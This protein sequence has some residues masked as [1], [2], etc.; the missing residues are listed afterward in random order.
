MIKVSSN[1]I[2]SHIMVADDC[3]NNCPFCMNKQFYGMNEPTYIQQYNLA[4]QCQKLAETPLR[5]F[6][7][8]GGEPAYDIEQLL[9][10]CDL[11]KDKNVCISTTLPYVTCDGFIE[12]VNTVDCIKYVNISRH[13]GKE[14]KEMLYDVASDDMIDEIIKPVYINVVPY[15]D[16]NLDEIMERWHNHNVYISVNQNIRLVDKKD[17]GVGKT[18]PKGFEKLEIMDAFLTN[19]SEH[20]YF[21]NKYNKQVMFNRRLQHTSEKV[22]GDIIVND[23]I[24]FPNGMF[25]YDFD[26][27]CIIND[28]DKFLE[29]VEENES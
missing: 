4:Y 12:L 19:Y 3:E 20:L 16:F 1:Q 13:A 29:S 10:L 27:N 21:K 18:L 23:I 11:L 24:L 28:I 17:F 15:L 26:K 6:H 14:D 5:F 25:G 7:I 9:I 22:N 8:T 2:E